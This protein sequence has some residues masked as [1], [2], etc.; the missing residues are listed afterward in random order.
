MRTRLD[1][2]LVIRGLAETRSRA[3]DLVRRGCVSLDGEVAHKPGEMVSQAQQ[4][5]VTGGGLPYVSRGGL[6][7]AAA[8]DAFGLAVDGRVALDIGASTGGFTD[9][10][11]RRGAARVYAVDVG[12]NQLA[13][14]LRDDSRVV[15][16]ERLDARALTRAEVPEPPGAIVADVSFIS[17]TQ[18]LPPAL[19][20]AAPDAWL[21]A[22]V[23]PQFELAPARIGK[24]GIVRDET[25]RTEAIVRIE[26]WM[27]F[28]LGWLVLG[29]IQSPITGGAGNAEYLL[30]AQHDG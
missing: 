24:R 19:S 14:A 11:L 7:L 30:A 26:R 10:L 9:V 28:Q 5:A 29:V 25:A 8:L 15:C 21:V 12:R 16:R 22:L 23:K 18:A 1:Q 13:P 27:S 3:R 4:L 6:K 20:L 17:L 2:A